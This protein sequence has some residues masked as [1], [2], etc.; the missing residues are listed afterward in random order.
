MNN[1]E[2]LKKEWLDAI[3]GDLEEFELVERK[4]ICTFRHGTQEYVVVKSIDGRYYK[5]KFMV[6][7]DDCSDSIQD[8]NLNGVDWIEVVPIEKVVRNWQVKEKKQ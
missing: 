4:I 2:I 5:G 6:P 8:Q 3:F 1:L 7:S